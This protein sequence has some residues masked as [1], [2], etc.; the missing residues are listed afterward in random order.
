MGP[1]PIH[2]QSVIGVILEDVIYMCIYMYIQIYIYIK[3]VIQLFMSGG[4]IQH[5][6][7]VNGRYPAPC[8]VRCSTGSFSAWGPE[9]PKA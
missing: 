8:D 9:A 5:I 7:S 2:E 4:S 1:A 3:S 6:R